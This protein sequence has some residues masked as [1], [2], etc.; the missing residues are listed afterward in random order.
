MMARGASI[1]CC[2][3]CNNVRVCDVAAS[4]W[5]CAESSYFRRFPPLFDFFFL[6]LLGDAF[7]AETDSG[8][9]WGGGEEDSVA[10]G[11]CGTFS[12][13]VTGTA[14]GAGFCISGCNVSRSH[15]AFTCKR[16][17]VRMMQAQNEEMR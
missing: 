15:A 6:C 14:G 3:I 13:S 12:G 11:E 4:Q 16:G 9:E 17:G 1:G 5:E 2:T 7:S 8:V 10:G